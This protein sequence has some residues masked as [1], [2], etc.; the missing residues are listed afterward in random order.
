MRIGLLAFVL[1]LGCE[2]GHARVEPEPRESTPETW[3]PSEDECVGCHETTATQWASSRHHTAFTN[4]DFTRSYAREPL[5]F[6]RDCHAPG[7]TRADVAPERAAEVGV[8]CIDCHLDGDTLLTGPAASGTGD[9][10]VPHALRR[11][12]DFATQACARCHEFDFPEHSSRRGAM[13]QTTMREHA[14]SDHA[15]R[16]C[17]DCHMPGDDHAFASTRDPEAMRRALSIAARREGDVL[18]LALRPENVGHAFPTGDLFRRLELHAELVTP[19]GQIVASTTRY[20][21]RHF[22]P[23]R[24]PDGR[25]NYA[26]K[27]HVRDDRP[28]DA[29]E[30]RLELDAPQTEHTKLRWWVDYERVDHRDAAAPEHSTLAGEIRLAEGTL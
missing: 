6:C 16:S 18:V 28:T 14:A 12:S 1:V 11:S 30:L 4:P 26:D 22:S 29:T 25:L 10:Q 5:D 13:M 2:V 17:A 8:G 24:R 19:E 21:A 27:Q 3:L 15:A 9:E 23:R 7:F 20:L